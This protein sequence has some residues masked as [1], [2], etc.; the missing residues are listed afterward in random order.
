MN[1]AMYHCRFFW[2]FFKGLLKRISKS[3]DSTKK[4]DSKKESCRLK[5]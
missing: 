5:S 4:H 3:V 1:T 2:Y